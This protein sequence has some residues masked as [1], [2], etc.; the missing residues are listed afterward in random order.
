MAG[1]NAMNICDY[2]HFNNQKSHSGVEPHA[3]Q[4]AKAASSHR[5]PKAHSGVAF[6][7]AKTK[8]DQD[9]CASRHKRRE[10]GRCGV[11]DSCQFSVDREDKKYRTTDNRQ[12]TTD[13][14]KEQDHA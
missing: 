7:K 1:D 9:R 10:D 5:T 3:L 11:V 14:K 8:E 2:E 13:N 12:P 6:S 4:K